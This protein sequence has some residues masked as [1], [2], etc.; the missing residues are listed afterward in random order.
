MGR[1]MFHFNYDEEW[2]QAV[3]ELFKNDKPETNP[4][5]NPETKT[6]TK[7]ETKQETKPKKSFPTSVH[8]MTLRP[9]KK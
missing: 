6:E 2:V 5:T 7:Q 3:E 1:S 4:E 8:G 9:R